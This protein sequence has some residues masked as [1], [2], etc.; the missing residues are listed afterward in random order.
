MEALRPKLVAHLGS[1]MATIEHVAGSVSG[2]LSESSAERIADAV[3]AITRTHDGEY[4]RSRPLAGEFTRLP[5][6]IVSDDAGAIRGGHLT[7]ASAGDLVLAAVR[8]FGARDDGTAADVPRITREQL[9]DLLHGFGVDVI[10]AGGVTGNGRVA[11][12]DAVAADVFSLFATPGNGCGA[13]KP[14]APDPAPAADP[15]VAAMAALAP[16]LP[17]VSRLDRDARE[18]VMRWATARATGGLPPS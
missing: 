11:D 17:L 9:A 13:P 12:P 15:E 4:A 18:R 5:V 8:E 7:G 10:T 1:Q 3:L 6:E 16:V 14:P 2:H